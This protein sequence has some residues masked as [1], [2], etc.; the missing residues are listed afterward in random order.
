[1]PTTLDLPPLIATPDG[2][3]LSLV[4]LTP[5]DLPLVGG[6]LARPHIGRWW[7]PPEAALAEIAESLSAATV[8]PYLMA[9]AI[10]RRF[11]Y[12]QIYHANPD[13]FW[14][15]FPLPVE[16]YGVDLFIGD[17]ALTGRGLGA[18]ILGPVADFL[19]GQ[20]GVARVQ[21]D[22]E[23][24]NRAAI[25]SYEKAGLRA[26]GVIETP[27]GAALYMSKDRADRAPA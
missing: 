8:F 17:Q 11:G 14:A 5:R 22:P 9:D 24:G 13:P 26:S 21:I 3:G 12:L 27:A 19:F 1:M 16:T 7:G 4:A 18:R 10:G 15:A 2:S 25:R 20:P 6:W 23:P